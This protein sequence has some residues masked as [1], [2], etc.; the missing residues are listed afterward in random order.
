MLIPTEFLILLGILWAS[1]VKA[2]S[3]KNRSGVCST[4]DCMQVAHI[5]RPTMHQNYDPCDNFYGFIF[6]ASQFTDFAY[7]I[8]YQRQTVSNLT[9]DAEKRLKNMVESSNNESHIPCVQKANKFFKSCMNSN[10]KAEVD[11]IISIL[12]QNGGWPMMMTVE[13]WKRNAHSWQDVDRYYWN[14][15]N[16]HAFFDITYNVSASRDPEDQQIFLSEPYWK[17]LRS[18]Q[19]LSRSAVENTVQLLIRHTAANVSDEQLNKDIM[20]L[21]N[22]TSRLQK[23]RTMDYLTNGYIM[24][25]ANWV[26]DW[27]YGNQFGPNANGSKAAVNWREIFRRILAPEKI[28]IRDHIQMDIDRP[29]LLSLQTLLKETDERTIVNFIHARYLSRLLRNAALPGSKR[30]SRWKECFDEGRSL[31]ED[32][33]LVVGNYFNVTLKEAARKLFHDLKNELEFEIDD[34]NWMTFQSKEALKHKVKNIS[35]SYDYPWFDDVE[36]FMNHRYEHLTVGDNYMS[37]RLAFEKHKKYFDP[38][39]SAKVVYNRITMFPFLLMPTYRR[40]RN[41]VRIP[42]SLFQRPIFGSGIPDY[43]Y[44]A[45]IGSRVGSAISDS[46]SLHEMRV[47]GDRKNELLS[48]YQWEEYMK[49]IGCVK[50]QYVEYYAPKFV[51]PD[52]LNNHIAETLGIRAAFNAYKRVK[53]N[54]TK[55]AQLKVPQF[56]NFTDEQMFF[57]ISLGSLCRKFDWMWSEESAYRIS[58]EFQVNNAARNIPEFGKAFNCPAGSATNRHHK[59]SIWTNYDAPSRH[60]I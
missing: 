25:V 47:K 60:K 4:N 22:F 14:L 49:R 46:L 33:Q 17:P 42:A 16:R 34:S 51:D 12:K 23:I 6:G 2:D 45:I 40:E 7:N 9:L 13:D 32:I 8:P 53:Q 54:G 50:G 37:N 15:T 52:Q 59:C 5:F 24:N 27:D 58:L 44:Y 11:Y 55:I 3:W 10:D 28:E 26:D 21:L 56:E 19:L 29:Y 18:H 35:Y 39:E 41:S 43:V 57:I 38:L 36:K 48:E 20:D 31:Y 30:M 1:P